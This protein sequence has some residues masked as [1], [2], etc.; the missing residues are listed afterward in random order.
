MAETDL[1]LN[2]SLSATLVLISGAF[3]G[4]TIA[5]MTQDE[6][7][8]QVIALS[9]A[10]A[11]RKN[12]QEVI[13]LL[14]Q[15][16][17][18]ILV[19]LL[20][21]NCIANQIVG[22]GLSAVLGSSILVVIFSEIIPQSI[23]ARHSLHIGAYMVL[24][25]SVCMRLLAPVAWPIG[26]LLDVF[27]GDSHSTGYKRTELMTLFSLHETIGRPEDRIRSDEVNMVHGALGLADKMATS[28]MTPIDSVFSLPANAMV[29]SQTL[30]RIKAR[31]F[32]KIPIHAPDNRM[33]IIGLL[34]VK[35]L[36]K[37]NAKTG[38]RVYNFDWAPIPVIHAK[39]TLLNLLKIF[40]ERKYELL[41]VGRKEK[42]QVLGIVTRKD[43]MNTLLGR[44][45][46]NQR[47]E[48]NVSEKE[49]HITRQEESRH[50]R[51][52]PAIIQSIFEKPQI[53]AVSAPEGELLPLW[54]KSSL[55]SNYGSFDYF[56]SASKWKYIRNYISDTTT[57]QEIE[58]GTTYGNR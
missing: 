11:D 37:Y 12:A 58:L 38:R 15:G 22:G 23:C 4:L 57:C 1:W 28:I 17:H 29:D 54:V 21:G 14:S 49:G 52:T 25:V 10:A 18:W 45:I 44:S 35:Q 5:L 6:L 40:Q 16:K 47:D 24:F 48:G 30:Q 55:P 39:T 36:L 9:G 20:L 41:L 8:L 32:S 43:V 33:D 27:V 7:Y 56:N 13:K 50:I 2:S 53:I 42:N 46:L 51:R 19:T 3:A 34:S 31:G 26:K